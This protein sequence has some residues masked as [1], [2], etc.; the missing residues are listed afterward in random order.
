M[1]LIAHV[2]NHDGLC[3]PQLASRRC[4][5]QIQL[6]L[7]CHL[8]KGQTTRSITLEM[9][10]SDAAGGR[11]FSDVCTETGPEAVLLHSQDELLYMLLPHAVQD[12]D[13][14]D[15]VLS[16]PTLTREFLLYRTVND[17]ILVSCKKKNREMHT[18]L[19]QESKVS[20][21]PSKLT[22]AEKNR[23]NAACSFWMFGLQL[24]CLRFS[25]NQAKKHLPVSRRVDSCAVSVC[26]SRNILLDIFECKLTYFPS[27][28]KLPIPSSNQEG[29]NFMVDAFASLVPYYFVVGCDSPLAKTFDRKSFASAL[30]WDLG[31]EMPISNCN[32]PGNLVHLYDTAVEALFARSMSM[33][34]ATP[35]EKM[36]LVAVHLRTP[37]IMALGSKTTRYG[38]PHLLAFFDPVGDVI[39]PT[40]KTAPKEETCFLLFATCHM[41]HAC[42]RH[43]VV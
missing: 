7:L 38:I 22:N 42:H 32:N 12:S 39:S 3:F 2:L 13:L 8:L 5:S 25:P 6:L 9:H 14:L 43:F 15:E 36:V 20:P 16:D 26:L 10:S 24:L 1:Q 37:Q 30:P 21:P 18:K 40:P 11:Q 19:S 34:S 27:V 33:P 29:P 31:E 41:P 4:S 17:A 35:F 23:G 28:Q